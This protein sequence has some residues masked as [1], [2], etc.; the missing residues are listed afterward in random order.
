MFIT[1]YSST[2]I[3]GKKKLCE[4][5]TRIFFFF[6]LT[7]HHCITVL[8][9][10]Y[11]FTFSYTWIVNKVLFLGQI[12]EME[13]LIDWH[14]LRYPEFENHTFNDLPVSLLSANSNVNYSRNSKFDVLHL[15]HV[16]ATWNFL[17]RLDK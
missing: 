9:P 17:E 1:K 10:L 8:D 6:W 11:I 5:H 2:V 7:I 4:C 15:Y 16:D 3:K 12:F 13:I 14:V